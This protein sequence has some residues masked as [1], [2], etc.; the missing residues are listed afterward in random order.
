M[1]RL[2]LAT[3]TCLPYA[4][5]IACATCGCSLSTDAAT[6]YTASA[7]WFANLEYDYINQNQLRFSTHTL[8]AAQV[9]A[10]ND[11][12]GDQEVEHGTINRYTTLGLTYAPNANWNIK[13]ALPYI[14][15]S[16][17]T[18]ASASNPL[19]PDQLSGATVYG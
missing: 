4:S 3:L 8:P 14:D 15:R 12:G 9:A 2:A 19:T 16:H 11:A 7:G 18:Y 13:L 10:I 5:A 6:G 1:K 17:T